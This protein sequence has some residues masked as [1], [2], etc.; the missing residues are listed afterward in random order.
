M[1]AW[2]ART[3]GV[4]FHAADCERAGRFELYRDLTQIVAQSYLAG[5]SVA[6]DLVAF[7]EL[8]PDTISDQPYFKCITDLIAAAAHTAKRFNDHNA[9]DP[10][11][12]DPQISLEFTLD[13]RKQSAG[14][15]GTLYTV[16][17]NQPEWATSPVLGADL[18]FDTRF[19][20]RIQIADLVAREAMK[21]S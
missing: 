4:V 3:N 9:S 14:T 17:R 21:G 19:N 10:I 13:D 12:T 7:R 16:F 18:K 15:A 20:P 1:A 11:A 2:T 6:L 5:F 8:F